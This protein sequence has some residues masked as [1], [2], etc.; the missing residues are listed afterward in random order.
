[1]NRRA[2]LHGLLASGAAIAVAPFLKVI[3]AVDC[4]MAVSWD[5]AASIAA[6]WRTI[7][8]SAQLRFEEFKK[9]AEAKYLHLQPQLR[10]ATADDAPLILKGRLSVCALPEGVELDQSRTQSVSR[11]EGNRWIIGPEPTVAADDGSSE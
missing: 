1:M 9:S 5:D 10:P 4:E 7:D 2:F 11:N 3:T 8:L 6:R